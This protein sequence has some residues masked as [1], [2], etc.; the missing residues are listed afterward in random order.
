M[1]TISKRI[2]I[3]AAHSL[4]LPYDSPCKRLHG[5]NWIITVEVSSKE[6]QKTG[7]VMDFKFL[8]EIMEGVIKETLDHRNLN[9]I[10]LLGIGNITAELMARW[11]ANE[12]NNA[13][14]GD[15]V[16]EGPNVND[17]NCPY[18]S[19]VSVQESEGNIAIW[20]RQ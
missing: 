13:L 2:E 5:H 4:D 6:L 3:S 7:M 9:E 19:K 10:N 16:R 20:E 18:V 11:I 17:D 1:F 12:V 8:K 14:T 15:V